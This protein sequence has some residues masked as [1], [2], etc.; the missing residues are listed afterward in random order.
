MRLPRSVLTALS[1]G[2]VCAFA[3]RAGAQREEDPILVA[4]DVR[5]TD[6]EPIDGV[7]VTLYRH[8]QAVGSGHSDKSGKYSVRAVFSRAPITRVEYNRTGFVMDDIAGLA[9]DKAHTI[10]KVLVREGEE[11]SEPQAIRALLVL[12]AAW[13]GGSI[14]RKETERRADALL[15][16]SKADRVHAIRR[17]LFPDDRPKAEE[18]LQRPQISPPRRGRL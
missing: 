7:R 8:Q 10:N 16:A 11:L 9:G 6:G 3:I 1:V 17:F 5:G 15:D 4:G 18:K 2:A 13:S 12:R 14:S